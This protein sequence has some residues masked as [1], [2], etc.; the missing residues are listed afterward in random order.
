M[1]I[2]NKQDLHDWA[3]TNGLSQ[4][5]VQD[6][7]D[8]LLEGEHPAFGTEWDEG[9]LAHSGRWTLAHA[10]WRLR[11]R[12]HKLDVSLHGRGVRFEDVFVSDPYEFDR[13]LKEWEEKQ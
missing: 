6:L 10:R 9:H 5:C 1:I 2:S 13:V 12:G 7:V 8:A 11:Q 3:E 4:E